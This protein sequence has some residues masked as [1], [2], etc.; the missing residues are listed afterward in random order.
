MPTAARLTAS[1]AALLVV[2]LQTR[3]IPAIQDHDR[4]LAR[5]A[6]LV[7]GAT[8]LNV[9][10][11]ATEQVPA[12][13]GLTVPALAEI[14]P[15]RWPKTTFHA[16]GAAKLWEA[17][18]AHKVRHVALAGIE[19]HICVAQSALELLGRGFEVQV[20]ADAVGSRFAMDREVA[21]RRLE[22]A[23]AILT[24]AEACLFEWTESAEHPAFRA[25][26]ALVKER[27]AD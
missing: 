3:L 6:Q 1:G 23:G 7:R 4:V 11:F 15:E 8:L 22:R 12:K 27:L 25:I 13:L 17:L 21:L 19:A 24:T 14:L 10:T 20:V 26:S 5:T 2:D 18:E 16:G 9:P